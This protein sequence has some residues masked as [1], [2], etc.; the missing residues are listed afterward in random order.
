MQ[1]PQRRLGLPAC[2]G[3]R[4]AARGA[5][6]AGAVHAGLLAV[7]RLDGRRQRAGRRPTR[8]R[9]GRADATSRP[10]PRS[11]GRG[12]G[13]ARARRRRCAQRRRRTAPVAG[14]RAQRRAQVERA[15][16]GEQLDGEHAGQAVDARG[17]A[18]GRPT[19]PSTRGPPASPSV[20]IESTLRGHGEPLELATRS[21][22]AC[23]GR[24]CSPEST[25]GSSAR[26]GG[27]PWLRATS[28]NRSVRRS[29]IE[30]D[31]GDGDREE[32][33][34]VADRRAVEVA[35]GLD[36]AVGQ[37]HRVVDRRRPAR[38]RRPRAACATVSRA[39]P[40]TCGAQRSE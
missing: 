7:V 3:Q 25:P 30:R 8:R 24:S 10:R 27:R 13:R 26:N 5:D 6:G 39:A 9:D 21:R 35:V 17:A 11:R 37:H 15:G 1:H 16:G 18:C 34:H 33:E 4:G 28:R 38:G 29:A 2:G 12:S 22:P 32:V 31:V 40:C 20:G 36:P 19:S 23:T 14:G